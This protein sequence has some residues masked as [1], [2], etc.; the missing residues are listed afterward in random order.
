MKIILFIAFC[1]LHIWLALAYNKGKASRQLLRF[2]GIRLLIIYIVPLVL[3]FAWKLIGFYPFQPRA[4]SNYSNF[5]LIMECVL[6][7]VFFRNRYLFYKC[8]GAV[9]RYFNNQKTD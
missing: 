5:K 9:G 2:Y 3:G 8:N 4:A 1:V 6:L 7:S